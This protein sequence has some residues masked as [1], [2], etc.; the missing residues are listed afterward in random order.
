MC[1]RLFSV[2]TSATG[3]L[4]VLCCADMCVCSSILFDFLLFV[5]SSALDMSSSLVCCCDMVLQTFAISDAMM[6]LH[7]ATHIGQVRHRFVRF[8]GANSESTWSA[9]DNI[10]RWWHTWQL[11]KRNFYL[12][13]VIGLSVTHRVSY[14]FGL[15]LC[16]TIQFRSEFGKCWWYLFLSSD[17]E[18][19]VYT[20]RW[21]CYTYYFAVA[22][23]RLFLVCVTFAKCELM[24]P[25]WMTELGVFIHWPEL[26]G[27]H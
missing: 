14:S 8:S 5:S 25:N 16:W 19:P 23:L 1:L 2:H 24:E 9:A 4:F 11:A 6:H 7:F 13:L 22:S 3:K 27:K 18:Q 17:Y 15:F 20:I 10:I 21:F 12:F 26:W